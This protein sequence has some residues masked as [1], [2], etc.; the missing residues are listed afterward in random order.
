[1]SMPLPLT[2]AVVASEASG[3]RLVKGSQ[4]L[5][6]SGIAPRYILV[7]VKE[8][9]GT[10]AFTSIKADTIGFWVALDDV[11]LQAC[12]AVPQYSRSFYDHWLPEREVL[13]RTSAD[14]EALTKKIWEAFCATS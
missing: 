9:A 2:V 13:V 6:K 11:A 5:S 4:A 8:T 14:F 7:T 12:K 1:M 3:L 10:S